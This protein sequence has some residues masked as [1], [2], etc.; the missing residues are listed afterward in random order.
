MWTKVNEYCFYCTA[1][2]DGVGKIRWL[3]LGTKLRN[4]WN[5]ITH[6]H[7]HPNISQWKH[8]TRK[9]LKDN[10]T[11]AIAII[12]CDLGKLLKHSA[13]LLVGSLSW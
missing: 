8:S 10:S 13:K 2:G 12:N 4:L 9:E 7:T 5:R 11:L 1:L 6:T 3:P